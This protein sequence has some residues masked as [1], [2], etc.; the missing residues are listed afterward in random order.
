ML[1]MCNREAQQVFGGAGYLKEGPG[2]RVEQISRE[3][4]QSIVGGGSEE[5]ISDLAMRQ[6]LKVARARGSHL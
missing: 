5:I 6:E 3:L 1:E 2:Q 4:R